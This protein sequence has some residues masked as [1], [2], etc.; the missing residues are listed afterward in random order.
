MNSGWNFPR[1]PV[2]KTHASNT[3]GPGSI[4]GQG[5]R[6]HMPQLKVPHAATETHSGQ[7]NK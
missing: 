1:G 3:E 7:T 5:T 6:P 2:A 4:C